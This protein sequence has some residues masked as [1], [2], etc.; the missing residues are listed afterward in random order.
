MHCDAKGWI[1]AL[2][3]ILKNETATPMGKHESKFKH[4]NHKIGDDKP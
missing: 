3:T 1:S 2:Q 4:T